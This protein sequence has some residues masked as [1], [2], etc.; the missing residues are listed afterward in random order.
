MIRP[1]TETDLDR[2]VEIHMAS[3]PDDRGAPVRR[4]NFVQNAMGRLEDLRVCERDGEL[5]GHAFGFDLATWFAGRAVPTLGIASVAVAPEARGSGVA[6]DLLVGLEDEARGR[7]ALVCILHA[8]RHGFYARRGYA[9]VMP[10]VR[11]ACDPRAIP[12]AWVKAARDA[13]LHGSHDAKALI[14]MY[15]DAC[16]RHTGWIRRPETLWTRRFASERRRWVVLDGAGYVAFET[17]QREP[18]ARTRLFVHEMVARDDDARRTLWGFLGMQVGQCAEIDV[19]IA[20][21]DPTPLALT[22]IDGAR[23]GSEDVEHTVGRVV[24]GPMIKLLDRDRALAARGVSADALEG[25]TIDD[26]ALASVAFGGLG[27]RDAVALDLAYGDHTSVARADEALRIPPF[28]TV[29][30]F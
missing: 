9:D 16:K 18:H 27:L 1:A 14:A 23:H 17:T 26:R 22:D 6:R 30:R 28:F 10:N 12:H 8:F 20:K 25:V 3:Y 7:G 5:V 24:A 4:L 13:P 15:D 29:D 2:L 21:D 19:E 11:L